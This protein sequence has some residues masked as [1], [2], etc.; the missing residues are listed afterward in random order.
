[1]VVAARQWLRLPTEW[2]IDRLAEQDSVR[3]GRRR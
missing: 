3:V 1:M 2:S